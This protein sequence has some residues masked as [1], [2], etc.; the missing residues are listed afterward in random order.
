MRS[1]YLIAFTVTLVSMM[2]LLDVTIVN[3]AIPSLMGTYGASVARLP[4]ASAAAHGPAVA[5]TRN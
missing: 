4:K 5:W 3:V 2:E 1:P